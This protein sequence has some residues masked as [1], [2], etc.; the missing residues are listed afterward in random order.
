VPASVWIVG[1]I[2]LVTG[3]NIVGIRLVNRVNLILI[4][5]Q[6]VFIAIFVIAS[7]HVAT[8]AG[9]SMAIALPSSGDARAIFAGSAI[10]CLSFLGFD[11][12]TTLSE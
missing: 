6:L 7:A 2:A 12:V 11:A 8:G 10:L 3:L 1:S 4:A 9:L 5:S